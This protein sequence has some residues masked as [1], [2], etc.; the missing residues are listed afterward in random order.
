MGSLSLC[1]IPGDDVRIVTILMSRGF[2]NKHFTTTSQH[3]AILSYKEFVRIFSPFCHFH[4]FIR[5]CT[6]ICHHSVISTHL[7]AWKGWRVHP[8][9]FLAVLHRHPRISTV[10]PNFKSSENTG[11]DAPQHYNIKYL[12]HCLCN[13]QIKWQQYICRTLRRKKIIPDGVISYTEIYVCPDIISAGNGRNPNTI[14]DKQ[15]FFFAET[16]VFS[17]FFTENPFLVQ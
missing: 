17:A 1:T 8:E 5:V 2:N 9:V 15:L 12:T 13:H 3:F 11:N 6:Y 7:Y 10:H 14:G 16:C 4:T